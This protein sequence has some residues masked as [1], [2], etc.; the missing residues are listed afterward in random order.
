MEHFG[1]DFTGTK[2]AMGWH[3]KRQSVIYECH[4]MDFEDGSAPARLAERIW[5][6]EQCSSKISSVAG[7]GSPGAHFKRSGKASGFRVVDD[8]C[9]AL[10][11]SSACVGRDRCN[12][13]MGRTKGGSVQK[14]IWPWMRLV[15]RS[16]PLLPMAREL[17]VKKLFR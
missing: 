13:G 12:E 4:F 17:T 7:R 5:E 8:G 16:E 1:A 11:S 14:F 2:R 3:C 9:V 6:M 15:C 10:Q